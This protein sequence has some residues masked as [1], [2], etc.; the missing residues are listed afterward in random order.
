MPAIQLIDSHCHLDFESFDKDR[1]EVIQRALD[2][3]IQNIIIPGTKKV[4]WHRIKQL[5]QQYQQLH[6][7]YGASSL[8]GE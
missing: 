8:L 5:C 4:Y 2:K 6:A 3:N 1:S 7:C